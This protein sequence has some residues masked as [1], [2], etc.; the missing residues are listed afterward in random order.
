MGAGLFQGLSNS[1]R[2]RQA[3]GCWM[4]WLLRTGYAD[5]MPLGV[6]ELPDHQGSRSAFGTHAALPTEALSLLERGLDVGN[7]HIE[8]DTTLVALAAADTAVDPT[9]GRAPVHEP[10]VTR[11]GDR[12][13]RRVASVVLPAEQLAVVGPELRRI[14]SDDLEVHNWLSQ[15]ESFL[16][17]RTAVGS[18]LPGFDV[19]DFGERRNSS[20]HPSAERTLL[21]R[22]SR[23]RSAA[24]SSS[25]RATS[26]RLPRR[27]RGSLRD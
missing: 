14:A 27:T 17:T 11:L 5:Q 19:R 12:L 21:H 23:W 2:L 10:V 7:A 18:V 25:A 24:A 13:G 4:L 1:T 3:K 16:A 20:F 26:R 22:A 9:A 8:Q 6:G 15:G